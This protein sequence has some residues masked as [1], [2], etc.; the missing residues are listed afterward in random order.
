MDKSV[1]TEQKM[2]FIHGFIKSS[3]LETH[4]LKIRLFHNVKIYT[5]VRLIIFKQVSCI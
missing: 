5:I 2:K 1:C 3:L 4:L